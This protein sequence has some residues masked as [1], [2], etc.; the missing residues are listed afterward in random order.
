MVRILVPSWPGIRKG[1]NI[2]KYLNIAREAVTHYETNNLNLQDILA[3]LIGSNATPE[4]CGKLASYGIRYLSDMTVWELQKEGL[5]KIE[6]QRIVAAFN[7]SKKLVSCKRQEYN[8]IRSPEDAADLMM[9]EMRLL[10]QEHFVCLYL[11]SKNEV[12]NKKTV[13][14]GSLNAS[15]VHPREVFKNAFRYGA[16][17][18]MC[19]H[20]HRIMFKLDIDYCPWYYGNT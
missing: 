15:V 19:L 7:M 20:N 9:E 12:I 17:S 13:F 10:Q 4:L 6:G 16:A 8:I 2:E 1:E 3:V 11:N 14:I 5:S 18:I